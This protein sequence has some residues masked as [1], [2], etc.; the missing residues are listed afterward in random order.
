MSTAGLAT[1]AANDFLAL[2]PRIIALLKTALSNRSPAVHV[3][4]A[5]DLADVKTARQLTPA[6]HVI[7]GGYRI[8]EDQGVRLLLSH[9]WHV[10]VVVSHVGST[11][12]GEHARAQLGPLLSTVISTLIAARIDGATRP[13]ELATPRAAWFD[14]GTQFVPSAFTAQTVF[15]KTPKPN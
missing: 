2:E 5:A 6:V 15:H 13:L 10:V 11:R 3:L 9:T 1:E 8:D 7:Y 4:A 12:S 14:A